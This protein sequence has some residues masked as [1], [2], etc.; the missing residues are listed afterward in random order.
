MHDKKEYLSKKVVSLS[1]KTFK[2]G[3][4]NVK[5]DETFYFDQQLKTNIH[6]AVSR[7]DVN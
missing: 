5:A 1:I 2:L 7:F 6:K 4:S 3:S